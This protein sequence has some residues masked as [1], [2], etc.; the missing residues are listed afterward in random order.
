MNVNGIGMIPSPLAI[1]GTTASGKS[2]LA[3]ALARRRPDIEIV[4]V[5]SMQ[6]YRGMDIGT[7]KASAADQAEVPHHGLDLVEP[8]QDFTLTQFQ[9]AVNA[10]IDDVARRNKRALL[11]GGTGLYLR[12]VID[13]LTIPPRFPEVLAELEA[14]ADTLAL[15]QRLM[16]L[17]PLA[18]SR[19][20]PNNRRR[21]LRA[22]E[23]CVGSGQPFSSFGPGLE[24]YPATSFVLVGIKRERAWLD[25]RIASRYQQQ[26]AAGFLDEVTQLLSHPRG[27]S[28]TASQALGYKELAGYIT[29][30][31]TLDD[32]LELAIR[33]T[34]QFARRQERWFRRDPRIIW[35]NTRD[36]ANDET[37]TIGESEQLL[38]SLL[39]I[40]DNQTNR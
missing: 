35:L 33:R 38:S 12:S 39:Q 9:T 6:V 20:E 14:E 24:N 1:V 30:E 25:E 34:R 32:A 37:D 7:A 10:A 21:I 5:D 26:M 31:T 40:W 27:W 18:A 2:A 3:M 8:W 11:V 28:R 23:V 22:L 15:H 36:G 17:D 4:S 19:M 13:A 16:V 29:G